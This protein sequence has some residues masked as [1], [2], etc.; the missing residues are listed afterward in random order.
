MV[1][2]VFCGALNSQLQAQGFEHASLSVHVV[3]GNSRPT[4]FRVRVQL[5]GTGGEVVDEAFTNDRGR[6][7]FGAL[8]PGLYV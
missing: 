7:D 1:A 2:L 6:A 3:F 4:D 5:L 8:E